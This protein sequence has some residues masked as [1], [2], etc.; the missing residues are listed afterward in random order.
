MKA[1]S[2]EFEERRLHCTKQPFREVQ[3]AGGEKV[4]GNGFHGSTCRVNGWLRRKSCVRVGTEPCPKKTVVILIRHGRRRI[5]L[6]KS[7]ISRRG[8][9]SLRNA[10]PLPTSRD[11][12]DNVVHGWLRRKSCVRITYLTV[13]SHYGIVSAGDGQFASDSI[14]LCLALLQNATM[15]HYNKEIHSLCQAKLKPNL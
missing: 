13:T 8:G 6:L 10:Q 3:R 4:G 14:P 11:R 7:E 2:P 9:T 12:D 15:R 1:G 5:S